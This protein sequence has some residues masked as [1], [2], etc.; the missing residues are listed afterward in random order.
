[1]EHARAYNEGNTVHRYVHIHVRMMMVVR[2]LF[3]KDLYIYT[4]EI[5]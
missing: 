1:M 2:E 5:Y 3:K 4:K